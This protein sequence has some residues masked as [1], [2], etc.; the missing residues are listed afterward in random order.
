MHTLQ[1]KRVMCQYL[2]GEVALESRVSGQPDSDMTRVCLAL[3][4]I[5]VHFESQR[6]Q[7]RVIR[8]TEKIEH[9]SRATQRSCS[10]S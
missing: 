3:E 6:C 9:V 10:V 8:R 1:N 7:S 5:R 2:G 4:S